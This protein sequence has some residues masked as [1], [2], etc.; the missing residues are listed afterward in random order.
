MAKAARITETELILPSLFL[1]D[2]NG[3]RIT[4][5]ELIIKL[6][7]IMKPSGE[8]LRILSGRTDDKFSQKVRNLKAH[9]TFE[10]F[11]YA[12]YKGL[13]KTGFVEITA[14]GKKHLMDNREILRYLLINDFT[15]SDISKTLIEVEKK[16]KIVETFDEN[17]IVQEGI[18]AIVEATIFKRSKLLRDYAIKFYTKAGRID[19]TCCE[20][21]FEDF[22]GK[23]KGSG[24]I[25][26]HHTKPI[27][28]YDD[29]D[30]NNTLKDA[31][32]NLTPL[33]SNCHRM[34][35]RNWSKPLEV[36]ELIDSVTA[37]G[38]FARYTI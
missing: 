10:R 21:N 6:R 24:F 4:T 16:K 36:Q 5:S 28:K 31:V 38:I 32:K 15:Y 30:I 26:I 2:I 9:S 20:F 25:E 17:V 22:Y 8:D 3:G 33:C 18:K 23:E 19:C 11:G 13:P 35:H 14:L 12:V 1:M 27:F 37:N 7:A 29:E 34:I